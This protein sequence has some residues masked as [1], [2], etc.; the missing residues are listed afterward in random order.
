PQGDPA[1]AERRLPQELQGR[2]RR[3]DRRDRAAL[4]IRGRKRRKGG[5]CGE[6]R[7][8][9]LPAITVEVAGIEP[10]SFNPKTGL[11]RAQP[12]VLFSAPAITQAS[13]RRAQPLFGF[14]II[15]VAGPIGGAF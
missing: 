12:A 2:L 8:T 9:A 6:S 4:L 3:Q 11:L 5:R 7:P 13:R 10:A 1:R 14:P 15:P